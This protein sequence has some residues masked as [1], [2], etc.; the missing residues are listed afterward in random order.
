MK[1]RLRDIDA[2]LAAAEARGIVFGEVID[3]HDMTYESSLPWDDPE[4][5]IFRIRQQ[6]G[7]AILTMKHKASHRSRD[8]FEYETVVDDGR[9]M[10]KILER[11][12][13]NESVTMHKR[14]RIAHY[15]NL[16]LCLDD[17]DELG[18]FVEV[19]R[20]AA[21]DADADAV[22]GELWSLLLSLGIHPDDRIHKG[23]DT[24]MKDHRSSKH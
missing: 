3:Q 19:E 15:Q 20:L 24:L 2:F 7:K 22:Q 9:Q 23:Y 4:W 18:V 6:G 16:E 13:Y 12:H 21:D 1:A 10:A 5:N 17:I 8:N 11:L 14:R